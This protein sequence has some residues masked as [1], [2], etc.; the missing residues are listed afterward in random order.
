MTFLPLLL[1]ATVPAYI[2]TTR[3]LV[4]VLCHHERKSHR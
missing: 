3:Y 2:T 1:L 4:Q